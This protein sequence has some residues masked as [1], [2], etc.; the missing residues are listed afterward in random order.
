MK[1]NNNSLEITKY[2]LNNRLNNDIDNKS[3]ETEVS[4]PSGWWMGL[5][6]GF[7]GVLIIYINNKKKSLLMKRS[8]RGAIIISSILLVSLIVYLWIL[9][10]YWVIID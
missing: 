8:L 1:Y 5:L 7:I 2:P 9:F 3:F 4:R 6:L 10:N